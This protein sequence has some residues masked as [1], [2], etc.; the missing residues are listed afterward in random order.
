MA[1]M[2]LDMNKLGNVPSKKNLVI[3][4]TRNVSKMQ[5]E[6]A[7]RET[8]Y[9][10]FSFPAELLVVDYL[11][12]SG[13]TS[14]TD[15]QWAALLQG[16]ESYGRNTGYYVLLDAFRDTFERGDNKKKLIDLVLK[17]EQNVDKLMD[18]LFLKNIKGG[19]VNGGIFQLIRPNTFIVPQGRCSEHL[20]FST[21]SKII[22][23]QDSSREFWI[24][25]NGHFDTTEANIHNNGFHP[26]NIFSKD[27]FSDFP[28]EKI[29]VENPFKGNMDIEELI[30]L[31][32]EKGV[33]SIPLIY[34]TITNNTAAGQP[35]S[36]SNMKLVSEIADKYGIPLFYDACRFAENAYFV[37]KFEPSYSDWSIHEIVKEM[38]NHADGFT[39]SFKKDGLANM[40]GGLFFRDKGVFHKRFSVDEDVG[41][42]LKES[43]ILL[44]GNDSYGGLSGRDIMALTTGLYEVLDENY[45]EDRIR[46]VRYM[47]ERLVQNNVP[48]VLPPGGHAVYLNMD[49][50]F[51]DTDLKIDDFG[52][53][54]FTL[55]LIKHYGI[56]ASEIGP[57]AFEWDQKNV[58]ERK[59][60]LNF[61]RFAVPRNVYGKEHID[62]TVAAITELFKNKSKIPKVEV[63]RGKELRLRHFQSGLKPIFKK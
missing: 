45:L 41:I 58:E 15:D 1:S 57:F 27:I 2:Y 26:V 34:L 56:R 40:G 24:P 14:M 59:G 52:G 13:T 23:K 35:V 18:E 5:R 62:Y 11:S 48:A 10:V 30:Q 22:R 39:I 29:T 53:V 50:F 4:K 21:L 3:R 31:I 12:D 49:N 47:A 19:F 54:G 38:F 20:L 44:F 63:I 7:L 28:I 51:K 16:D 36:I 6:R 42:L 8:E 43:Q 17:N 61:V 33:E 60:I 46:Q 25:S 32:D 9:N 37:K 55:E